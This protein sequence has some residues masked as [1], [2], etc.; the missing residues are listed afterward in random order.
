[1][2]LR[3]LDPESLKEVGQSSREDVNGEPQGDF[4]KENLMDR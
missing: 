1:M 2:V 3:T 4:E